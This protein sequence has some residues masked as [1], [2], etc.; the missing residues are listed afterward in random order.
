MIIAQ[1]LVV[2]VFDF[3]GAGTADYMPGV[4]RWAGSNAFGLMRPS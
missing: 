4:S 3:A 1:R 2:W